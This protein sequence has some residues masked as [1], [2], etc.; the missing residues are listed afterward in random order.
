MRV[1]CIGLF[2][3][4]INLGI[5]NCTQYVFSPELPSRQALEGF[6]PSFQRFSEI[7]RLTISRCKCE[8]KPLSVG[9]SGIHVKEPVH[10]GS[11]PI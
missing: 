8:E 6:R 2:L 5:A 1:R 3:P 7:P 9:K 10:F 4:D 11:S